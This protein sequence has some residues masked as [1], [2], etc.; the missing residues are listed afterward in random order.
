MQTHL[1]RS[2]LPLPKVQ[3]VSIHTHIPHIPLSKGSYPEG[4]NAMQLN[5][6]PKRKESKHTN[7]CKLLFHFPSTLASLNFALPCQSL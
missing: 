2:P 6:P 4:K 7:T 3:D 1:V 5:V